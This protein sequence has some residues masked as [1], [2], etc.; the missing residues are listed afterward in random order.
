MNDTELRVAEIAECIYKEIQIKHYSAKSG[1]FGGNFGALLFLF[2]Y[3]D[4]TK[5]KKYSL[6]ADKLSEL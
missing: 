1:L 3:A 5:E 4:F 2:Y 6:L